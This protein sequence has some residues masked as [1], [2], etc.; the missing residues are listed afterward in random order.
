MQPRL[1]ILVGGGGEKVTMRIAARFADEWNVW[2]APEVLAGKGEVLEQHCEEIG[3]DPASIKRTAQILVT[4][5]DDSSVLERERSAGG[6]PS[7]AGGVEEL[8][9]AIGRYAEAKVDEFILPDFNL[10]RTIPERKE[11]YDRFIEDVA[12]P[13]R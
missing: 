2:G 10:G 13:F 11:A 6:F 9:D 12:A 3:R 7:I 4:L 8:R 5:S 1:P